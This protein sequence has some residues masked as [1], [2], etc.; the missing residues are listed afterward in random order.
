PPATSSIS[1]YRAAYREVI[2][3]AQSKR[4][5]KAL[6]EGLALKAER[7]ARLKEHAE[8]LDS[9]KLI[10]DK[11][12]RLWV[13]REWRATLED[14]ANEMGERRPKEQESGGETIK[15]IIGIDPEK[16]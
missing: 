14:I 13:S 4:L 8:T 2:D 12:G 1:Y 15:V 10:P 16:V 7:V 9:L 6:T 11:A 3:E 5:D